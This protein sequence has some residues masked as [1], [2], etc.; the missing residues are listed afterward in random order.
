MGVLDIEEIRDKNNA[1]GLKEGGVIEMST[2][3]LPFACRTYVCIQHFV[4]DNKNASL[5]S[6]SRCI[7]CDRCHVQS[8]RN[9]TPTLARFC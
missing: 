5:E 1:T 4:W 3:V 8:H 9:P 7:V 2:T 6:F